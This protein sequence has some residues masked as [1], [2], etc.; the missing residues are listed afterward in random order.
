VPTYNRASLIGITLDSILGQSHAPAEVI[1]VDDGSTE[2][3]ETA[4]RRFSGTV[5]YHRIENSGVCAARNFGVSVAES[6][7]IAFCDHDDLW[8]RDKLAKQVALH[9]QAGIEYSFTNFR[10]VSD[11]GWME[12]TKF[13]TAPPGF[14]ND[15]ESTPQ[16][17]IAR[18]PYYDD[19]LRYQPI[20]PSTVLMSKRFFEKVGGIRSDLGRNPSEDLEFTLRCLQHWPIG[21]I[22]EPVVGIHKHESNYSGNNYLTICGQIEI[23]QLVLQTH[24]LSARSQEHIAEQIIKRS[25][26]AAEEAFAQ[27]DFNGCQEL[28]SRVPRVRMDPKTKLKL[29][30]ASCPKPIVATLHALASHLSAFRG[31]RG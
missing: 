31:F 27:A 16:G 15:F 4:I 6:P 8:T 28:L 10:I 9:E 5:K 2:S 29:K 7:W 19:L 24:T 12:Q 22:A 18:R 23:L 3:M 30:I 25:I 26:D 1:V 20:F 11:S 14:F 21:A 13:D 17:L